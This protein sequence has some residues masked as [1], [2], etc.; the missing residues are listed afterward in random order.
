MN[1]KKI[2]D[3]LIIKYKKKNIKKS[4]IVY[5]EEHH[6]IPVSIGGNNKKSNLVRVTARVHFILHALLVRIYNKKSEEY[7]SML[8]AFNKMN[9]SNNKQERYF[10]SRLFEK[11]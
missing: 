1:Y 2:Y 7:K 9:S 3:D 4:N 6:I 10:N 8:H 5:T 11:I